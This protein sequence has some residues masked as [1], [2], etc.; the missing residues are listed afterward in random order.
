MWCPLRRISAR[1]RAEDGF[2]LIEI[3]ITVS[4]F[5]IVLASLIGVFIS[6]QRSQA[7]VTDR[8]ESMDSLRIAMDRLSKE[9]RQATTVGTHSATSLQMVT[10]VGGSAEQITWAVAGGTLTR[11]DE[12]GASTVAL[13]EVT[14][15]NI[16][17]YT[18]A[19]G[20]PTIIAV[21]LE[22]RPA[23]SPDILLELTS[24]I[25]LRNG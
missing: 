3:T 12:W 20:Q 13:E 25:R 24:E 2:S 15:T 14:N 21:R 23:Q 1:K 22:M 9:V 5:T 10:F 4:I 18:P 11:T 19:T 17:T 16:F 6:I 7:Y 8:S